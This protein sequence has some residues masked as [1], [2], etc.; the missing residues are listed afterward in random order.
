MADTVLQ[1]QDLSIS[2]R[3]S[4]GSVELVSSLSLEIAA[5]EILGM[6]GESGSGKTITGLALLGLLSPPLFQSSGKILLQ[7]KNLAELPSR[8]LHQLRGNVV[9]MV[10]Q[11]PMSALNPLL[12]VGEQIREVLSAHRQISRRKAKESALEMMDLVGLPDPQRT[13]RQYPHQLSG[14]MRQRVLIAGALI[15]RPRLLIADEPTTALDV[16]IQSEIL[17]LLRRMRDE[18]D[19]AILY[20]THDL[21]VVAELCAR[22]LVVYAGEMVE[23]GEV[24]EVLSR[25]FHPYTEGLLASLPR[26]EGR[27]PLSPIPGSVPSPGL[28]AEG[29]RFHPRCSYA[30][31]QCRIELQPL[32]R[33]APPEP[34]E[35]KVLSKVRRSVRCCRAQELELEGL[36]LD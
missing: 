33:I 19:T 28:F 8:D 6:V 14:G 35:A 9:S 3:I 32:S 20:I 24:S 27:A 4:E 17:N 34:R 26:L 13:Y 21:A 2:V 7:G 25:P 22:V 10:F 29:C 16:T 30:K 15:C 23:E 11:E 5:G 31:D 36:S 1:V 12:S 18:F